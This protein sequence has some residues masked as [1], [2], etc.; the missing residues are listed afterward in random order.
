MLKTLKRLIPWLICAIIFYYLFK[1]IPPKEMLVALQLVNLP[2]F[3]FYSLL[4]FILI[5]VLD[6]FTI[7]YFISRF[8]TKITFKESLLVRGVSYLIM[9]L[10]YHAAQGAF[11]VYFKKTHKASIAKTLGTLGFISIADLILVFTSGLVALSFT[12]VTYKGF[13]LQDYSLK[14]A[15]FLYIGYAL[16]VLFWKNIDNPIFDPIKKY[17]IINWLLGHNIFLIFREAGLK[18][19]FI[20]FL[21][22]LPMIAVIIGAYNWALISYDSLINWVD[23]YLYNPIVM[24][25]TTLPITPSGLGTGQ[26]LTIEFF[27]DKTTSPLV[28]QGLLTTEN[29]LLTSNILWYIANQILKAAFGLFCISKTSRDLFKEET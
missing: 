13:D 15:P 24:L 14:I 23:I 22:R 19:Y 17:K 7:T 11:A 2:K 6:C 27:K 8:S 10:N 25:V 1:Q 29:L 21:S 26:W 4:Y 5:L 9:I 3:I 18:D 28:D 12:E 20:L 16:W